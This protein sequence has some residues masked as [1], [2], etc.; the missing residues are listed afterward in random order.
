[1]I[2]ID[3]KP[4]ARRVLEEI[5]PANDVDALRELVSDQF[6][7]HEAPAGTPR[8]LVGSPCS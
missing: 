5:F 3:N 8:A 4:V 2:S 1:M 6:V 7:N